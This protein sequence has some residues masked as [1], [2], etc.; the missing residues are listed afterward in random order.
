MK[1]LF[2]V[3]LGLGLVANVTFG[4]NST[5]VVSMNSILMMQKSKEGQKLSK[6]VQKAVEEFQAFAKNTQKELI[7]FQETISK[8][9]K[10]LSKQ[11]LM[12]KGEKLAEM[13][14][15]AEREF[16]DREEVLKRDM[17]RKHAILRNKQMMVANEIFNK[18]KKEKG[19]DYLLDRNIPG[20][21]CV[22]ERVDV[23]DEVLKVVD[24][25]YKKE[26]AEKIVKKT[27]AKTS[28]RTKKG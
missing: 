13:K 1:K 4:K 9:S 15:K 19:W 12:E 11:A 2:I 7:D 28:S 14:K 26:I 8:Q 3:F 24:E 25:S 5:K 21:L 10:V 27:Q 22:S 23:T 6:E 16:S 18:N 17:Q 20:L